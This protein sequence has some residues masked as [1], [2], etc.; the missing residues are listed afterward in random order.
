M[1]KK[2]S[3]TH[4]FV[5]GLLIILLTPSFY[6]QDSIVAS[7]K[8]RIYRIDDSMDSRVSFSCTDSIVANLVTNK[9]SMYGEAIVIYDGITMTADLI[10]MDTE[11]K[12]VYCVY[13]LDEDGNRVGIPKFEDGAESFTAATIRYNFGTEKGYIEELKT[14]Q[15]EMYLHMGVAKRHQNEEV[16]FT[17][18]K[19][20][21]CELDD[22]HFHFQLSKAVMVPNERIATGPMNLWVKGIPTPLGLP[23]S[24][25]PTKDQE[26][27]SGFI[28]PMFVPVSQY[29]FGLQ[30]LGY[31]FP[32]KKSE[33]V[34]TTFYGSLYSRG[35]FELKNQTDYK[36][37]YKYNG[38][39]NL[40][41]SSFRQPFPADSIRKQKTVVQWRHQQEAKANPYWRFNSNVNFQSDN[42]GKTDLDPLSTQH[43]QN[44]FNSDIN[45]IR[46]FPGKPVT[47]GLKA[48]LKQNSASG[49]LDAD[50]PTF[51]VNV[52]RFFP[53]KALRK[54]KIGGDKFY[55][56]IGMT[57]SLEAKNRAIF[58]DSLLKEKR[59]DLIENQFQNGIQHRLGMSYPLQ[60]FKKVLTLNTTAD[61]NLRMN[62]QSID[63]RYDTG[64]G[65]IVNDTLR[66]LGMS[67][68][69]KLLTELSTNLYAYYSFVGSSGMKMRHVMTPRISMSFQPNTSSFRTET[70]GPT[71]EEVY[72]S[73][74]ENSLYRE[75]AG[76]DV[77]LISY[78][79]NNT[80]ELKHKD[81]KDTLGEFKK[82]RIIDAFS[83]SGNYDI[84]KDSMQLSDINLQLRIAPVK[85]LSIVSRAQLSPYAWDNN[86]L[87][88]DKYAHKNGQG[89]G[90]VSS[91]NIS[92]TYTFT[93]S[94]S[95]DRI[96]NTQELMGDHWG[97]DF[98]YYAMNPHEVIDF[99]IPW[100]INLTHTFFV[101]LNNVD[102]TKR[103]KQ[104]QN[105]VLSGDVSFTERWKAGLN[106][107]YD[108]QAMELTQT[109]LSLSRDMHCWQLSF[110]WTPVGGQQSF[111]VRFNATSALFQS[112][113]LELRKPPEF[114]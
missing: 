12:E 37:R 109:R 53:F 82:T 23:F 105:I 111:L 58:A 38:V 20:T 103:Y 19:F 101:N 35:T 106:S 69:T 54:N 79:L 64:A 83:I 97:A 81:R 14:Q 43:Y 30:D 42:N 91:A 68:D 107:S 56:K 36:K 93:S 5:V 31:Y 18:G 88:F 1:S 113:K 27:E 80:F 29:G 87:S 114:L 44:N 84:F 89:I 39:L 94:E 52:N 40:G 8:E 61:Y 26:A 3:I 4:F 9:I 112:A 2:Y 96:N 72:Y 67:H 46:S 74:F 95:R 100:K 104:N 102:P 85:G 47:I 92:T 110:Y 51:N 25:I 41:Y 63:K 62:F 66:G 86:G 13:T 7:K 77:G 33:L 98:Q 16:H 21:T 78:S 73:P 22:P 11:K 49:N 108:L 75:N 15:E 65:K 90:R 34:Q 6:A 50:L 57:Y 45:L 55:E 17:K 59:Y 71:N 24:V 76:R 28:F 70:L 10:E 60:L 99:E 48:A 32:I